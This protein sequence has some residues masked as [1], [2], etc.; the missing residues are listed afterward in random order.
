[1][2]FVIIAFTFQA[3]KEFEMEIAYSINFPGNAMAT[4]GNS[5]ITSHTDHFEI[6]AFGYG[7]ADVFR[8]VHDVFVVMTFLEATV[9]EHQTFLG[10]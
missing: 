9:Y 10:S 6:R 4:P 1:M 7:A 8:T 5:R 3:V 2:A